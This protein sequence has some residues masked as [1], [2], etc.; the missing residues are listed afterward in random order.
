M[1]VVHERAAGMDLSKRD[2][3]VAIRVP[4]K[5][6]GTFTTSVTTWGAMVPQILELV[7]RQRARV[8]SAIRALFLS[9]RRS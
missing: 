3:K 9:A 1:D 8:A 5:R 7:E 6:A 4:G 2:A